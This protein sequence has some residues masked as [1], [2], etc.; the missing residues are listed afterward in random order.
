MRAFTGSTPACKGAESE[1]Q[2][3][4]P[5][6]ENKEVGHCGWSRMNHR[7]RKMEDRKTH[8]QGPGGRN[9]DVHFILVTVGR[10]FYKNRSED[11]VKTVL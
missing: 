4:C 8:V 11:T 10:C 1:E 3:N 5:G 6:T 7:D 2:S 9:M